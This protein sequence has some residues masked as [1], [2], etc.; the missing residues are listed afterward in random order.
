MV[1]ACTYPD[2]FSTLKAEMEGEP[3]RCH[4]SLVWL[5]EGA[6]SKTGISKE[7]TKITSMHVKVEITEGPFVVEGAPLQPALPGR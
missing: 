1:L 2:L 5:R 7:S 6:A 3:G 4:S